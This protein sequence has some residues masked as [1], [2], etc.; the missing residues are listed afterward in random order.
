VF[1]EPL[2]NAAAK[3][4]DVF[5]N[6]D[7]SHPVPVKEVNTDANGNIKVREQGVASITGTVGLDPTRNTVKIDASSETPV[8]SSL[9]AGHGY[10]VPA[11]KT[12]VIQYVSV[13]IDTLNGDPDVGQ[14]SAPNI[15]VTTGGV[16]VVHYLAPT[17]VEEVIPFP[18]LLNTTFVASQELTLYADAD[19]DVTVAQD[20]SG[21][22]GALSASIS[23][24]LINN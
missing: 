20:C 18:G 8:A 16:G 6:N 14:S 10:T 4:Q 13:K 9:Y 2:A 23:G 3:A 5:I 7:V 12:L 21:G 11:G 24:Y 15:T 17:A 22:C 19:T 1:E